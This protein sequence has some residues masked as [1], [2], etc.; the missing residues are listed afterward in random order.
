MPETMDNKFIPKSK[1][2]EIKND[3]LAKG[4]DPS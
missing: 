1:L 4:G 2:I 3:I